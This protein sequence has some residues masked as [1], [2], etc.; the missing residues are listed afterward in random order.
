[1]KN[2]FDI[3]MHQEFKINDRADKNTLKHVSEGGLVVFTGFIMHSD[4]DGEYWIDANFK[5]TNGDEL[6][7]GLYEVSPVLNNSEVAL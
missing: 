6:L 1:M 3:G 4:D 5:D 2:S 7:I